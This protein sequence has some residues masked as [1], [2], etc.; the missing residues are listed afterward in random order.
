[1]LTDAKSHTDKRSNVNAIERSRNL[2]V[3]AFVN[4]LDVVLVVPF[5]AT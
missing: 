5:V 3:N 2:S 1:M 4:R